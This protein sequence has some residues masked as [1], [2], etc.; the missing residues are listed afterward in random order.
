[1][2]SKFKKF[3]NLEEGARYTFFYLSEF[4]LPLTNQITLHKV[5]TKPYAQYEDAVT[6]WWRGKGKK[7]IKGKRFFGNKKYLVY[8]GWVDLEDNMFTEETSGG[9]LSSLP[10]FNDKYFSIAKG[11]T[12]EDPTIEEIND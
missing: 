8:K 10:C 2:N 5:E 6:V 12:R 3:T 9:L 7:T 1:M 4:G 11:S